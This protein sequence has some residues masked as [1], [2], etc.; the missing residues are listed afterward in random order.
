MAAKCAQKQHV[1]PVYESFADYDE[2]EKANEQYAKD[3]RKNRHFEDFVK[4]Y[5]QTTT[6]TEV[7]NSCV[8]LKDYVTGK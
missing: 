7:Y 6:F 1:I 8:Y 2:Y 5:R 4:N 3:F